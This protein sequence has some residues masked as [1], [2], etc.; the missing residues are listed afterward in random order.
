MT[1]SGLASCQRQLAEQSSAYCDLQSQ[2]VQLRA[3]A[4]EGRQEVQE[5]RGRLGRK[6][7]QLGRVV[8]DRDALRKQLEDAT[9]NLEE[10]RREKE[11]REERIKIGGQA[12]EEAERRF[13]EAQVKVAQ[14]QRRLEE[15]NRK[16]SELRRELEAREDSSGGLKVTAA[17]ARGDA[18][19]AREAL[20]REKEEGR[21][22]R[23]EMKDL[24]A[25]LQR[26]EQHASCKISTL[27]YYCIR[28]VA[29][30]RRMEEVVGAKEA[31]RRDLLEQYDELTREVQ[32]F[33]S[34]NRSLEMRSANL[35]LEVRAREDDLKTAKDRCQ[36]LE[37]HLEEILQQN[38]VFRLQIQELSAKVDLLTTNLKENRVTRDSVVH[39]LDS[40]NELAVRLNT[41]KIEL[42]SKMEAQNSQVLDRRH[43]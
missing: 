19:A 31:A 30:V 15:E 42:L 39:D 26:Y 1:E 37:N 21:G 43:I 18:E 2:V 3:A 7:D 22:R 13:S 14:L 40:V 9:R 32:A 4:Q 36:G 41:E 24:Q 6:E 20:R 34:A 8:G 5:L 10:E 27:N 28:Y 25:E 29:E 12:R 35:V 16:V 23:E 38:Q 33:E 17:E 11:G